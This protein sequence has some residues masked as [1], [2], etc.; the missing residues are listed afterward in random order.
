MQEK[1]VIEYGMPLPV[2][3]TIEGLYIDDHIVVQKV[4]SQ[5]SRKLYQ[6]AANLASS[7]SSSFSPAPLGSSCH[8]DE[9][10][11][12]KSRDHYDAVGLPRSV[13]KGFS[14]DYNFTAWGTEVDSFSGRVGVR[15]QKLQTIVDLVL[16][17]FSL[18]YVT[19][20]AMQQLLG[21]FIHPMMH[22]RE[23]MSC[24]HHVFSWVDTIPEGGVRRIP[25]AVQDELIAACLLLPLAGANIRWP[26]SVRLSATDATPTAGGG[27]YT[28]TSTEIAHTLF[29]FAE[30][31][32]EHS[33]L[34]WAT[35]STTGCVEPISHMVMTHPDV[36]QLL[37]SHKWE[38]SRGHRFR[39][40]AHVNLQ[41]LR[42]IKNEVRQ[43]VHDGVENTRVV[44]LSD[45]RVCVGA[46]AKGRSS[47]HKLNHLLRSC[48]GLLL[49]G[50]IRLVNIWVDTHSNP[51][52]APSR[53][54]P[55]E[56]PRA[57][58]GWARS[59]LSPETID[60][61]MQGHQ[62]IRL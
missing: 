20:R 56:P 2:T 18:D 7:S 10:I 38:F 30:H 45:S 5:S 52:D 16:G 59:T 19:K 50:R 27:A 9:E 34:D 61:I 8:R 14:K 15:L 31:K 44:N 1:E 29:R 23:L 17:A 13:A 39:Q 43:L 25:P 48:M 28:T 37:L 51:S 42:A 40:Q 47:S 26:V 55:M 54:R 57:L 4:L 24:F 36:Q 11:M 58:P 62:P 35:T 49:G 46:W 22:R 6:R 12:A 32:G 41:E 60:V 33:R 3:D 21:L 53:F